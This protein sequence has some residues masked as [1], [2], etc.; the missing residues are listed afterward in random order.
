MDRVHIKKRQL[1]GCRLTTFHYSRFVMLEILR[2]SIVRIHS[3]SSVSTKMLSL[4]RLGL[5]NN[6]LFNIGP[7]VKCET[8]LTRRTDQRHRRSVLLLYVLNLSCEGQRQLSLRR[9]VSVGGFAKFKLRGRTVL[10]M[11]L[12]TLVVALCDKMIRRRLIFK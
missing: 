4:P 9:G 11:E 7:N 10:V 3:T 2:L 1:I 12:L 5:S 8:S 6:N